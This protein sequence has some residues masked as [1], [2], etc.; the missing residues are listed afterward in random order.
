MVVMTPRWP[1]PSGSTTCKRST[2]S[3]SETPSRLAK[4]DA[5]T[6]TY[7]GARNGLSP[8]LQTSKPTTNP[9]FR[10]SLSKNDRLNY[11][12]AVYCLY[13]NNSFITPP[14]EIPGIRNR[15][16]DFVGGHLQLTPFVHADGLFLPFHRFYVHLYEK[17]LREE[18]GYTGAQPY[19]DWTLSYRDPRQSAV[20]DGSPWS[21]GSNGFYVPGREP[22]I[23][24]A[25]GAVVTVQPGTGGG[26]VHSGPFTPDK[27]QIHLGPVSLNPQGPDGGQGYNPRC[28]IRDLSL[29]AAASTRP[30]NVTVLLDGCQDLGCLNTQMDAAH[31]GVHFFGHFQMGG[32]ALDVFASPSDPVFW[33]HHAQVDRLWTIWQSTGDP[34][35]RRE[36]VWGTQTTGNGELELV[37]RGE[38]WWM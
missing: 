11:I 29:E 19:W 26:C 8:Y 1:R 35:G 15:Y 21:M 9:S 20:F 14:S 18:C 4:R 36:Q 17:A 5:P 28:L 10:S 33:L 2:K 25:P 32:I 16:N 31:G 34:E 38:W 13:N 37:G 27:F 6:R 22:T 23:V 12:D 3:T 30:S 7:S 24:Q